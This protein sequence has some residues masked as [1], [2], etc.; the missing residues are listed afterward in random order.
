MSIGRFLSWG[1]W[2]SWF[3]HLQSTGCEFRDSFG[4]NL[5]TAQTSS[6]FG[7]TWA[8]LWWATLHFKNFVDIA[9]KI[10][11]TVVVCQL[12]K[13]QQNFVCFDRR[14]GVLTAKM[15]FIRRV[16]L[17]LLSRRCTAGAVCD[18]LENS[19]HHVVVFFWAK[20]SCR[21]ALQE[22]RFTMRILVRVI[23]IRSPVCAICVPGR[24]RSGSRVALNERVH[25]KNTA[26]IC[27]SPSY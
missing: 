9:M 15:R 21:L 5:Q 22:T 17:F 2:F 1:S 18:I 6:I 24:L 3:C 7:H 4:K 26:P 27:G 13:G 25:E 10:C 11:T 12:L 16:V 14:R 20:V 19:W 8:S 23:L